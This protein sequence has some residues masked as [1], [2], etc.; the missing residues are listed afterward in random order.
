MLD[1]LERGAQGFRRATSCA[2]PFWLTTRWISFCANDVRRCPGLQVAAV[3]VK[4]RRILAKSQLS[5]RGARV[6]CLPE[7]FRKLQWVAEQ[8]AE[9]P[10]E[11]RRPATPPRGLI[12]ALRPRERNSKRGRPGGFFL[13]EGQDDILFAKRASILGV[14]MRGSDNGWCGQRKNGMHFAECGGAAPIT[15]ECVVD[16]GLPVTPTGPL[17]A[18]P[19]K[20]RGPRRG[21]SSGV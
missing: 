10:A 21:A 13:V 14:R 1:E 8:M 18:T 15:L 2:Q 12:A 16:G 20:D 17:C 7:D 3:L 4:S 9:G 6:R 19:S 11:M 5:L